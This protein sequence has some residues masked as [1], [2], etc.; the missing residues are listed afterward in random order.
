MNEWTEDPLR[1]DA[2]D[3]E[4]IQ[5]VRRGNPDAFQFLI[6][7]HHGFVFLV[8]QRHLRHREE[9]EDTTQQVFLNAW[10]HL[11]DFRGESKFSTWLYTIALNLVRNR[12]RQRNK[13]RMESLD[14]FGKTED[15]PLRQWP[16]RSP[17]IE[18][19]VSQRW[20]VDQVKIALAGVGEPH[21]TI[22]ALHYFQ[23][24][25][26]KEVA[27]RVDRPLGTVKVYLHRARK[28]VLDRM[29]STASR[30]TLQAHQVSNEP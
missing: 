24:L 17:S 15:S 26:L 18:D 30:V 5:A 29:G 10:K 8:V 23:H 2:S 12:V 16:D 1:Y 7:R 22:F 20:Q 4:G 27:D 14:S 21:R 9:A 19:I 25:S 13:Q 3:A 6:Q 28:S 11:D